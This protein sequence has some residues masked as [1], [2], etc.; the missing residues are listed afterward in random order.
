MQPLKLQEQLRRQLFVPE[1]IILVQFATSK[2]D[3]CK[4]RKEDGSIKQFMPDLPK[5]KQ[6]CAWLE[7]A[8]TKYGNVDSGPDDMFKMTDGPD[9]S[10]VMK[11]KKQLVAKLKKSKHKKTL[12]SY[13]FAGHG[14][15][16]GGTQVVVINDFDK[17]QGFYR[18][19][20]CENMIRTLA[21]MFP[22]SFH[23][24]FFACCREIF[25]PDSH[26]GGYTGTD[27]QVAK[28]FKEQDEKMKAAQSVEKD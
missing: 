22:N 27:E 24:A 11:T 18:L 5:V 16:E 23:L 12:V 1:Q 26:C 13:V 3:A 19:W 6:D 21:R 15:Q 9:Y 10:T 8:I 25:N 14:M 17:Q 7:D 28:H 4:I 20:K 2:Y